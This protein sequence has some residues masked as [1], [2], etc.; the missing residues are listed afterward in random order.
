MYFDIVKA[1]KDEKDEAI[2]PSHYNKHKIQ[3][4]NYILANDLGFCEGNV[5]KYISRWEEKGYIEDLKKAK[6]YIEFLIEKETN[7]RSK[8]EEVE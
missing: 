8:Q 7:N 6:T 1:I 3:P 4:I 2:N 5:I